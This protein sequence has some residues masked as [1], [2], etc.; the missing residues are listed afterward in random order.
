MSMSLTLDP[1]IL[2]LFFLCTYS[3][4]VQFAL[5]IFLVNSSGLYRGVITFYRCPG[6]TGECNSIV[7]ATLSLDQI[8]GHQGVLSPMDLEI[9]HAL[10]VQEE[11]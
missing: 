8:Y 1:Q 10:Q 7:V 4:H 3:N 9:R 6:F 2:E 11:P 5:Y